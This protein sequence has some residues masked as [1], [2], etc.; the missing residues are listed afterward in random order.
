[1]ITQ[2]VEPSGSLIAADPLGP[3]PLFSYKIAPLIYAGKGWVPTSPGL[4][5][6]KYPYETLF[7][8][9]T[10]PPGISATGSFAA[11]E[12]VELHIR[13]CRAF[14][15]DAGNGG[16]IALMADSTVVA[17]LVRTTKADN[18]IAFAT[19]YWGIKSGNQRYRVGC[20]DIF[21]KDK[22]GNIPAA[23]QVLVW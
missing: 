1:M 15:T 8:I 4:A 17:C 18:S 20:R 10:G 23:H 22:Q 12:F 16:A 9:Q 7:Q 19:L 2:R 14:I 5:S 21:F 13:M 11:S 6:R 3:P